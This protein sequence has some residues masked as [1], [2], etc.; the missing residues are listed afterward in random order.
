MR[1]RCSIEPTGGIE[2]G[3]FAG[4]KDAREASDGDQ[5]MGERG[6]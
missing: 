2:G 6:R 3:G 5:E 1:E 4:R